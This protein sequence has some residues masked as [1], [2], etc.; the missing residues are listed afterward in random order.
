MLYGRSE[1]NY[2]AFTSSIAFLIAISS[3]QN[4]LCKTSSSIFSR[5]LRCLCALKFIACFK[6]SG[7]ALMVIFVVFSVM[8]KPVL[9]Q[10]FFLPYDRGPGT[11]HSS[12]WL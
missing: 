9:F 10:C 12:E 11:V 7:T 6:V 4:S 2:S 8:D 5:D 3:N 1:Y